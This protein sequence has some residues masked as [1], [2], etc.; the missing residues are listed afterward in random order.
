MFA[1]WYDTK[2]DITCRFDLAADGVLRCLP[3]WTPGHTRKHRGEAST[4]ADCITGRVW[5]H[6][7]CDETVRKFIVREQEAPLDSCGRAATVVRRAEPYQGPMW[8]RWWKCHPLSPTP[9]VRAFTSGAVV[10]P[11][12]F[13][14]AV[15]GLESQ[16][17]GLQRVTYVAE[18]G[19]RRL[20]PV[21]I[22]PTFGPCR[23]SSESDGVCV[24]VSSGALLF[25]DSTCRES[26]QA[27]LQPDH[28]LERFC[29]ARVFEHRGQMWRV[30]KRIEASDARPQFYGAGKDC[31]EV[32]W[33]PSRPQFEVAERFDVKRLRRLRRERVGNGRLTGVHWVT[34][35]GRAIPGWN[36]WADFPTLF[37]ELEPNKAC[38]PLTFSGER[39]CV[40]NE[41]AP[42]H[43]SG[44]EFTVYTDSDCQRPAAGGGR[45]VS[46]VSGCGYQLARSTRESAKRILQ[47]SPERLVR[48]SAPLGGAVQNRAA[49][50]R[51]LPSSLGAHDTVAF[52]HARTVP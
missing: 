28:D 11:T 4:S 16:V 37:S 3:T 30:G 8:V 22:D 20:Q 18:D 52:W 41:Y 44:D 9:G 12:T 40:G 38:W 31:M 42:G 7:P 21:L 15:A 34:T 33:P 47:P 5:L 10:S 25:E 27:I 43:S 13:V 32:S 6:L 46:R 26:P 39:R 35:D 17:D 1:H 51:R 50:R 19:A 48:P 49:V 36:N 45:Q 23:V 24:P 2:L 29:P 14:S